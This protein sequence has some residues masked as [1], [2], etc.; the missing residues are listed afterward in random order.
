MR[1][2]SDGKI[3]VIKTEKDHAVIRT[4]TG[5]EFNVPLGFLIGAGYEA[6]NYKELI[7]DELRRRNVFMPPDLV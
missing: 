4:E 3:K 5:F 1:K 6:K 2:H 7:I